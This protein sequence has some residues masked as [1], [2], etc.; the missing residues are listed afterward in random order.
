[1]ALA[2]LVALG[3]WQWSRYGEKLEIEATQAARS[4]LPPEVVTT[5]AQLV[6]PEAAYRHV[7]VHGRVL[8][9]YTVRFKFRI[10]DGKSGEWIASPLQLMDGQVV[11]LLRGWVD[12]KEAEQLAK[13][14]KLP[15]SG[16]Y[17][18]LVYELPRNIADDATRA[19]LP[20][21]PKESFLAW[22]TF[23]VEAVY[24]FWKLPHPSN[25]VV[26]VQTEGDEGPPLESAEFVLQPYMNSDKHLGYAMTWYTLAFALVGLWLAAGFGFIGSRSSRG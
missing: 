2:L 12:V 5:S 3:T 24:A 14:Q 9:D 17:R 18:G 11:L 13:T 22:N 20:P 26:V 10:L 21:A 7:D 23:D 19:A 8:T 4:E 25:K 6:G 15:D 16:V 1:M